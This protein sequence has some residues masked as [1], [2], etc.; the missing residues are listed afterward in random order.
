MHREYVK[1]STFFGVNS[2]KNALKYKIKSMAV[3][4][5]FKKEFHI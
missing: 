5:Y 3:I 2:P 1:N 4:L